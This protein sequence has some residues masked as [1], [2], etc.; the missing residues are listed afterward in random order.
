MLELRLRAGFAM[1]SVPY[2]VSQDPRPLRRISLSPEMRPWSVGGSYDRP[3][4]RR[5]V[6]EAGIPRDWF[7]RN[8]ANAAH[9]PFRRMRDERPSQRELRRFAADVP[10]DRA[11]AWKHRVLRRASAVD[12][13]ATERAE[14]AL[15]QLGADVMLAPILHPHWRR[16]TTAEFWAFHWGFEKIRDRYAVA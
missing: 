9:A 13:W 12:A 1:M 6:E 14:R 2:L 16:S 10:R 11:R 5:I 8:K 15:N 4:P 3:I 7:G